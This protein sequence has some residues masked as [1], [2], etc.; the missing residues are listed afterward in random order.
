M[1]SAGG[2]SD[3]SPGS[4]RRN[5]DSNP[6]RVVC[7]AAALATSIEQHTDMALARAP[8]FDVTV[9]SFS[10]YN[11]RL[12]QYFEANDIESTQNVKRRASFSVRLDR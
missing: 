10:A 8:E 2:G 4:R 7:R 3:R 6:D 9:E 1:S 11:R 5:T 12:E